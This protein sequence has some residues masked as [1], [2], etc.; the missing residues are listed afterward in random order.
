[1]NSK[2]FIA[3]AAFRIAVDRRVNLL[4]KIYFHSQFHLTA[5][6]LQSRRDFKAFVL[7]VYLKAWYTCQCPMSAPWNDLQLLK[8]LVAYKAANETV[9]TAAITICGT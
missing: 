5:F 3:T 8:Q 1:M 4:L 7:Q 2:H 6:E 9:A